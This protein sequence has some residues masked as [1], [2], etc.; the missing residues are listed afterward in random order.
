MHLHI[1]PLSNSPVFQQE[2]C[3]KQS[4]HELKFGSWMKRELEALRDE[5]LPYWD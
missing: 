2:Q 4:S 3:F 5:F 1:I